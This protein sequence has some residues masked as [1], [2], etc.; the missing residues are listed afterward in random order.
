[1]F[2]S[3]TIGFII[4]GFLVL[5]LGIALVTNASTYYNNELKMRNSFG[6][7]KTEMNAAYTKMMRKIVP[8]TQTA[9]KVDSSFIKVVNAQMNGQKNGEN[10]A[11]AW[12]QQVNPTATFTEVSSMYKELNRVVQAEAETMFEQEKFIQDVK[13]QHDNY[14]QEFPHNIYTKLFGIK[15]L[16]YSPIQ[17]A[18]TKEVMETGIE[19]TNKLDLQ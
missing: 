7:K 4:A 5:M 10:L 3:K 17:T 12:I 14:T 6:Q 19:K 11:W 18:E 9:V 15:K 8:A 13:L 16:E 2:M 1:M